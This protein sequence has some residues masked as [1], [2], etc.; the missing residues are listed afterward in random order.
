M[1]A[2]ICGAGTILMAQAGILNSVKY[3]TPL[4]PWNEKH[5]EIFDIENPFPAKNY[6]SNKCVRDGNVIT[7]IGTAFIEFSTEICDYFELFET[8]EE[9]EEFIKGFR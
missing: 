1:G 5:K 4:M 8:A 2:G 9:K 3:T 7:S 6:C